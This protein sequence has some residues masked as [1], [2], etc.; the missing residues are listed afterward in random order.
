MGTKKEKKK[1]ALFK[2]YGI[3]FIYPIP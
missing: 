2:K 3:K 1:K